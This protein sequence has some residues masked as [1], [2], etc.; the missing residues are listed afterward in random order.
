[1]DIRFPVEKKIKINNYNISFFVRLLKRKNL[2]PIN[3][4][5]FFIEATRKQNMILFFF[6]VLKF[7]FC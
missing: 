6:T 1:M 7:K 2:T 3:K 4:F 5:S